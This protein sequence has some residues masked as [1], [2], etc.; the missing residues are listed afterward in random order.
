MIESVREVLARVA[1]GE[2]TL[3]DG[4]RAALRARQWQV[5]GEVQLRDGTSVLSLRSGLAPS[6]GPRGLDLLRRPLPIGLGVAFDP[7]EDWELRWPEGQGLGLWTS[8]AEV[9]DALLHPAPDQLAV[10]TRGP[11]FAVVADDGSLPARRE[12]WMRV[13]T[14][15]TGPDRAARFVAE[16][17][18]PPRICELEQAPWAMLAKRDDFDAVI[19]D[20]A[21]AGEVTWGPDVPATLARGID[22]RPGASVLAARTVAEIHLWLDQAGAARSG[23]SHTVRQSARGLTCDYTARFGESWRTV[24]FACVAPTPDPEDLGEGAT[25]ILCAGALLQDAHAALA[26]AGPS[27]LD[28]AAAARWLAQVLE[29]AQGD[30]IPFCALRTPRGASYWR[31]WPE[32]FAVDAIAGLLEVARGAQE[33]PPLL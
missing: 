10:L 16:T 27:P 20:P 14:L 2:S 9:E 25:Q 33:R 1:R 15:F 29:V 28:L 3:H 8:I 23:R 5:E 13:V 4:L 26:Q 22:P 24:P 11:W 17:A 32:H 7:E 18:S 6:V 30:R 12:G 31:G 21:S 19:V